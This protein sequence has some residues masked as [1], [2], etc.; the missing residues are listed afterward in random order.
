[1]PHI[2]A[3]ADG[4]AESSAK[5]LAASVALVVA[6]N[7]ARAYAERFHG[8]DMVLSEADRLGWTGQ[9][10]TVTVFLVVA[11]LLSAGL[12]SAIEEAF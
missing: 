1:M 8:T 7:A 6:F 2:E 3:G 4:P 5:L 9:I 11:A 12:N 10:A